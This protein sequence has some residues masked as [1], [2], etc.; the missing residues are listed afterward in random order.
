MG[1]KIKMLMY[2]KWLFNLYESLQTETSD[3]QTKVHNFA[4]ADKLWLEY[5]L[6]GYTIDR[7]INH[8]HIILDI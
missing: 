8:L 5:G 4:N 2:E 6:K 1:G 3:F 7:L